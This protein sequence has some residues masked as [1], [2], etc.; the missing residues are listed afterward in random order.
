MWQSLYLT[1]ITIKRGVPVKYY[2]NL[3]VSDSL[4]KK[5]DKVIR[6]LERRKIQPDL[7][8]ILLPGCDHNQLEIVNAMYLLQPGYPREDRL[9]VGI[10]KG[11]DDAVELVETISR[12]VYEATGNLQLR[13]YIQAREQE[14]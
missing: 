11:W 14:D 3:Y 12:E 4:K 6:R 1:V 10:A 2:S 5:K 9:V 8:V 13:D 7:H